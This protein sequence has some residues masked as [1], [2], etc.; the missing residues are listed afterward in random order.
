ML[1]IGLMQ[2]YFCIG[3]IYFCIGNTIGVLTEN[4]LVA[5]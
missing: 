4:V 1:D 3:Y 2:L 5:T